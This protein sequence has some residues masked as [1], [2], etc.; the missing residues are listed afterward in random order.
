METE[1][2]QIGKL[3][4]AVIAG[5]ASPEQSTKALNFSEAAHKRAFLETFRRWEIIFKRKDGGNV[6]AEKWL[7]AEYYDSLK[8]LSV[9]GFAELTRILRDECT[10][11]PSIKE[12]LERTR[13]KD[14]WDYTTTCLRD[15]RHFLPKP[16]TFALAGPSRTPL[17]TDGD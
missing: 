5:A 4:G 1:N 3:V 13:P 6:E 7:I 11:F 10:F 16:D 8:H 15:Q 9:E 14:K 12:C 2:K 17:L